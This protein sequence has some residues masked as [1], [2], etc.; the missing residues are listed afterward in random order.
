MEI[1]TGG[2][3]NVVTSVAGFVF[4]K[5]NGGF[6]YVR[7]YRK[8]ILDFE[9]KVETLKDKRDR[10]LLDVDAAE[11]NCESIYSDVRTWLIKADDLIDL[12]HNEVK[13][14][15][16]K[17]NC[18]C[19]VGLCPNFKAR[20][21]LCKRAK[22]EATAVDE[23]LRSGGFD[24]VSYPGVPPPIVDLVPKDFEDFDSRKLSF[25]Y[26]ME[27]VKDP[28]VNIVGVHGMP[29]VGK[30]TLVK[31]VMR[32]VKEDKE[33]SVSGR[34]S[35]LCQRMKKEKKILVVLDDVW[36]RLDLM[37]VGIPLGDKHR[38]CTALLTS[39]NLRVLS[40]DM[41][42]K[43]CFP[44]GVLEDEEAWAFFK[45]MARG[46]VES[47]ELL[48]IA[49]KVAKKC[50]GL[51]IAI[52]TLAMSLRDEPLFEW[53][54]S[55]CQLNRPSSSNFRG[56][57]RD[58][59]SAIEVSYDRLPSEEH[60]QTFLLCSLIGHDASLDELL[61]C[62]IGLGLFHGVN[63]TE[64]TRKRLLTVVSH[65][66]ASCLLI[67]S[68]RDHLFDMHDLICDVAVSIA[69]KG[70]H[71]FVLKHGDV[72]NDWPD[73]ETM[74]GC[75]KISLSYA[76]IR[77]LPDQLKC[78][79]LTLFSMH[80][81]DPLVKIPTN[82]F[83]EMENLKVLILSGMR[84]PSLPSSISLLAN[85]RTLCLLCCVL[86][87]I[88][89][90]GE[91]KNLEVL[92]LVGSDIESLPEEIGQ[93]K[94]L[95]MCFTVVE[96]GAEGHSSLAELEALSCLTAL[97]VQIPNYNIIPK[98]IFE[99]LQRYIIVIG[100][101]GHWYWDW[102]WDWDWVDEYSRTLKLN[103]QTSI[104]CL[105]Y[106]IKILLKKAENLYIDEVKG[107]EILSSDESKYYFQQLK[108]LHIENGAMIQYILKDNDAV[109]RNEFLQLKSLTLKG[110]PNLISFC[111]GYK[112]SASISPQ[113]QETTLFNQKT[114]FPKLE[115][116][117]LSSINIE[118]IWVPQA[119]CSVQNLTSLVIEGCANLER[120][121][122]DSMTEYLQQ[123]KC[124]EISECKSIRE[125]ISMK[126]ESQNRA[127]PICF[128]RLN[129]LKL[130]DLEKLIGFCHEGY[131]VEFPALTNIEIENCPELK[132]FM[133][134]SLSRD[135][136]T[137]GALF[138]KMVAFPNLRKIKISHLR[139]VKS[140]WHNH[141]HADSFSNLKE[142]EV[143]YC[144]VLLNIF[145]LFLLKVFQKL[146][147]LTITDCASLQEVFQLRVQ[148]LDIEKTNVVSSRLRE[149]NL[150][151]LPKLKHVW[152]KAKNLQ[153]LESLTVYECGVKKIVSK[154]VE[155]VE[156]EILF[157]FNRL[158][159][160][161][162]W[163]L[164]DL[165]CF[166]PG[167][168]KTIWP[169]LKELTA[170]RCWKINIF[171]HP[172]YQFPKPLFIMEQVIPQLEHVS[173]NCG[174]IA[175]ISDRQFQADLFCNI[176]HLRIT[177]AFNNL[178]FI[179]ICFLKR[180]YNLEN[181]EVMGCNFK[182][183]SPYKG[184]AGEDKDMV[185]TLP[186][187]KKLKLD[188]V[189]NT[190]LMWTQEGHISTSLEILAIWKCH[191]L[192]N[193]GSYFSTL[194]NLTILDV[195]RCKGMR[196]LVTSS[197]AQSLV[198][199]VTMRIEECEMMREVVASEGDETT[200]EIIFEK[201]KCLEFHCLLNL[202]SFCSGNH[203][204]RFPSL[205]Q[206][207]LSQC[208]KINNFCQGVLSTPKLQ[209][210]QLTKTDF[211]GRWVGDLNATVDQLYKEQVGYRGLKHLKFSE[212]PELEDVWSRNPQEMLYFKSL[213]YL[214]VCDSDKL[215][216]IFNLSVA[217]SLGRLQQLEIKRCN[218]LEHVIK[219]VDSDTVAEE[220]MITD[221]N[222]ITTVFPNLRSIVLESC[223]NMTSFY[224][225]SKALECPSL[226]RI[227]VAECPNMTTF[228]STFSRNGDEEAIIGDET[229]TFFSDKVTFPNLWEIKISQL[230]NVKRI[231][232]NQLHADSFSNLG[233]L[234]VEH[235][236][237][238]LNIFP[239]H[240][241]KVFQKLEILTVADCASL[242]QVFQ[243]QVHAS[244]NNVVSSQLREVNLIRLP[245]LK[246]VWN[247]DFSFENL[248]AV[249]VSQCWSLKT[250]FPFSIAK[251]LLQLESLIV[252]S[253]GVE[254]IVSKIDGGVEHEIQFEFNQLSFL[255][256]WNLPN[257]ICFYPET[258]KTSWPALKKLTT[259]SCGKIKIFGHIESQF[260]K[261]LFIIK[262]VI[263]QLEQ[264]SFDVGDIAMINDHQFDADFFCNIRH[265]HIIS[266]LGETNV[267]PFCFL[268]RF[269]NLDTLEVGSGHFKELSPSEDD[270]G[271]AKEVITM[272][273]KIKK[274]KLDCV[275]NTRLLWT[276]GDHI[277]ASLESLEVWQCPS[278]INL[279]SY[280]STLQN[281]TTLDVWKCKGI[282]ELITSCTAQ[283]LVCLVTMRIR[284]CETMREVVA[285]QGDETADEIVFENLKCL[286]LHCLL[287]LKSFCSGNH[288]FKFPSLELVTV[289]QCPKINNFCQGVLS[290]PKLQKVQLT[291]TDFKGRWVGDLNATVDQ[292]YKEQ[293][294][295][296]GL[297]HLKFSL[298]P[299]LVDI[300]SRNPQEMMDLKSVEFL[301]VCDLDNLI[302]IF[303]LSVVVSLG[304]LR[305]LEIKR[306]SHLE[307]VIK[308]KDSNTDGSKTITIFPNLQSIVLES[309]SN[310]TSFYLGSTTLECPS[311]KEIMVADCPNMTTFVS[312]FSR[313]GNE[314]AIIGDEADTFFSDK[315]AF[316]NLEKIVVSHLR[317]VKRIWY[318]QLHAGSY[319]KLKELK[320]ECC[321]ALLNIFPYLELQV[322]QRLEILTIIDCA[323]LEQ[324]FQLQVHSSE[325]NVVSS[326]LREVNLICLPKLKHVWNKDPNGSLSFEN[327][328]AVRIWEC[329]SLK[330]L[331]PFSIAKHLLQLECLIVQNCGVE[332]IV[333]KNF[334]GIDQEIQFE[335]NQLSFIG[336]W[337]LPN[338][339][340]FYP[341]THRLVWPVL[342]KLSTYCCGKTEIFGHVESQPQMPLLSIEKGKSI[343]PPVAF[344]KA[345]TD[346][347]EKFQ[348]HNYTRKP[349]LPMGP[350]VVRWCPPSFPMLKLNVDGA[351]RIEDRSGAVGFVVRNSVGLVLGGGACFIREAYSAD[352]VEA[353]AVIHALR[354]ASSKGFKIVI[355]ECG[356]LAVASKLK[357]KLPDFSMLG[358]FLEEAKQLMNSFE[359]VQVCY[360]HRLGNRVAHALA[361]FGFDCNE[362][363]TFGSNYPDFIKELVLS[364]M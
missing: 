98:D 276:Q 24:R 143:N 55:L 16:D 26:I 313:K 206:V 167:T 222:K 213:E 88:S 264:V 268:Q 118:R 34:A 1:S 235:C 240:L 227:M 128:P 101:A 263:P 262:Q 140:I 58:A 323:S 357:K 261:P 184:D 267:F 186:K 326:Q 119:I 245:K 39:R 57:P 104:S 236:N 177:S 91:L 247:M 348:V 51:P 92:C 203:T 99:K 342:K 106:G 260:L 150:I 114:L 225:G 324:V 293:V 127:L 282:T 195:W 191:S 7:N 314:E 87:D 158:S 5:I 266:P 38:G 176:K 168:H 19:L 232:H 185:T 159:Y 2:V 229:D 130:K 315:V 298:F 251:R 82:F 37:E 112:G 238:L 242:E 102:D 111:S 42:A 64:E 333:S 90:A 170:Y 351:F 96:W 116:L 312:T 272:L 110:L 41:D 275:T 9:N 330:T 157:E 200:Y 163:N 30:T 122:S 205:E 317:N 226:K 166:Y 307:Q 296:R 196:E 265:L 302:C 72:L 290:T 291:K 295:Y 31:E 208:P 340:C 337:N 360:V 125:I 142:L 54:D 270:A 86:G 89:I 35:R 283:S 215:R 343:L 271:E 17:A 220:A 46:G 197:K 356:T 154:Y 131:T 202:K 156:E 331:F 175:M 153:Q 23:L 83:K 32:Q 75:S 121:L 181:L 239:F 228:V 171:E 146:E 138:I 287:S 285:S 358:L 327:L 254:K 173:F 221:G 18:K 45:T 194:Q 178:E 133:H 6:S 12:K 297:K 338:L 33:Q 210:V 61:V 252:D 28:N 218:H 62:S 123:L 151:R 73:D 109:L 81:K 339:V 100:E 76:N 224:L 241:Q 303:N 364:C 204:F 149:V 141:L 48:P 199:L 347:K 147:I 113:P 78:S 66:K 350:K 49:T 253:C 250:L 169:T 286:E 189:S 300:W 321:D 77:K 10:V 301:E 278:L 144:N 180:F 59:Y 255:K 14:L 248:R 84:F 187:L 269:Y 70:N 115:K 294:G 174:D 349:I 172:E 244:E 29:G 74:K 135:I 308:E 237:A 212:F 246:H 132:G 182:E 3:I 145:P 258:H 161:E 36:A 68:Y 336:L 139:N 44:I 363:F 322:F 249:I 259:Y 318:D 11:K 288:T 148:G 188:Y 155:G 320:V 95:Y 309:C 207:I 219:D 257:L 50:G 234:E 341:G 15:E 354:F 108:N 69:S 277:S 273:P 136:P 190:R 120:V 230:R 281:L 107:V 67:D 22:E 316:P 299:E 192:I 334:E 65:L 60:K 198:C 164:P 71:A 361:S 311:L 305:Q 279:G 325:N 160:L 43:K 304:R 21:V 335:F 179:S 193:L 352:F 20:Y 274:L 4:Q 217:L 216:C 93:L 223:S 280:F 165:K 231:W 152:S 209:K 256:L 346:L 362:P 126:E 85:L 355:I 284:E 27:A 345:R 243:L 63:T 319:S 103:L 8:A 137:D 162:L 56:V 13:S 344:G 129:S 52:K 329:W 97:E 105:N 40:K 124:L 117:K 214:E 94:E 292:L 306:C 289:I 310:M 328:Q 353:Q 183:L 47:P 134:K 233:K 53:E 201:L 79:K 80:S 25:N 332:E 211:K 359:D